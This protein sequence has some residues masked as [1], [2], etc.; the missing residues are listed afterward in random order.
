MDESVALVVLGTKKDA[1]VSRVVGQIEK[2]GE[3]RV[4]VVDYLD[5]CRISVYVSA[6]GVSRIKIGNWWLPQDI[7]VWDRTKLMPGSPV[8][9]RGDD[10][11]NAN[12]AARE[13]RALYLLLS[14]LAG[15]RS[16]NSLDAKKCLVKP[17]Q[18][19]AAAAVG[20]KVPN[21]VVTND[22]Q[23][24]LAF[25]RTQANGVIVKA[26]SDGL[27]QPRAEQKQKP[28]FIMTMRVEPADLNGADD[29]DIAYSPHFF[30]EEIRKAY[31]LRIVVVGDYIHA[32]KIDSQV[33]K[34]TS[35]DWRKGVDLRNGTYK[36]GF[37]PH[38][39]D[40]AMTSRIRAFMSRM[41]LFT[42]S[43]DLM[44]DEEGAAWFLECNQDGAWA[45]LDNIVDGRIAQ[46]F[47]NAFSGRL[48]SVSESLTRGSSSSLRQRA[49]RFVP[50]VAEA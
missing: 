3:I 34:S 27:V 48:R 13:W 42:G 9:V 19:M 24:A 50:S 35:I 12:F 31:E 37:V 2:H 21:T 26:I 4:H 45:W 36:V 20:F 29:A 6:E 11:T 10:E 41:N 8:Y 1:H 23:S 47:A 30:Q 22:R 43:L 17:F 15:D 40:S 44:I 25:Q 5:D 46:D 16:I 32:F 7:V 18:Q 49:D 14:G 33:R 38:D 28:F 39:L